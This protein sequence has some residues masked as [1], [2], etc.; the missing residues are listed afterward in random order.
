MLFAYV[1]LLRVP[2][3]AGLVLAAF[4]PFALWKG[5]QLTTLLEG[6]F[7]LDWWRAAVVTVTALLAASAAGISTEL[8]LRYGS[9]RFG[10]RP[11]P[12][13]TAV[14]VC[15]VGGVTIDR[16]SAIIA[17]AYGIC[18]LSLLAGLVYAEHPLARLAGVAAG[19]GAFGLLLWAALQ[20][21]AHSTP[22]VVRRGAALF[23]WTP[24][25]YIQSPAEQ[26]A[27][28]DALAR[29][30]VKLRPVHR[31]AQLL[32]PGHGFAAVLL[33]ITLAVY[34]T[35]GIAKWW[36]ITSTPSG[37]SELPVIPTLACVLLLV[38]LL[39]SLFAA[40]AFM[41]DRFRVPFI[42]P[43]ALLVGAAADWPQS[44]HFFDV[45][46]AHRAAVSPAA[47]LRASPGDHAVV[48]ATS[49]GG[50]Q[51]AAWTASVL[52]QLHRELP[53]DFARQIRLISGVSGGS[54]GAM[55]TVNAYRGGT[56]DRA[57]LKARVFEPA[58]ASSL[59]DIAWGFVYPDF[60]RLFVP[61]LGWRDR[62]WAA[63]HAWLRA[64][65][66]WQRARGLDQPLASWRP[67]TL[68]ARR[69]A[70]I[71][72][73][74]VAENGSRI[75]LAT[76]DFQRGL[77]GR[78]SFAEIYP[79]LDL[80]IVTAAR[81]SATFP[82]VIPAARAAGPLPS[83]ASYHFVDG[84]YYDNF[85]ISSVADWLVEAMPAPPEVGGVKRILVLQIRGPIGATD[86]P[87][88]GRR[89]GFFHQLMAPL[90]TV[91][92]T[93]TIS[94][95]SHNSAELRL[96]CEVA[97]G[98]GVTLDTAVFQYPYQDT[99]LSWHLTKKQAD[100]VWN[101]YGQCD[102]RGLPCGERVRRFLAGGTDPALSVATRCE[103]LEKALEQPPRPAPRPKGA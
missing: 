42:V 46:K 80:A 14:P 31:T 95:V 36:V 4:A 8:V 54:V 3:V 56:L 2:V 24:A 30:G 94:Q 61:F 52:A 12:S 81:L 37:R 90:A 40:V 47:V 57:D 92:R 7:D 79:A 102:D 100:A 73:A 70:V 55:Y 11:L 50:I 19:L 67:D 38:T 43:L 74:T 32:L 66:V 83:R 51:A 44:D 34:A 91:A 20:V 97:A 65:S 18:A 27:T 77:R 48:V 62:G 58:A 64:E 99:P 85:G 68:A 103:A 41:L 25:G 29:S 82:Y 1:Y 72:N 87:A 71:F 86:A 23:R 13:W 16:L 21:W 75:V 17:T 5:S 93:R 9:A 76:T 35:F 59:D 33:A 28:L 89:R 49:G 6:M 10:L 69:P 63:E 84:G 45:T 53:G 39:T 15:T 88:M 78:M 98:R 26:A 22:A 96:L 101:A 60:L